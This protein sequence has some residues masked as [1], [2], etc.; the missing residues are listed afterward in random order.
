MDNWNN[1]EQSGSDSKRAYERW[2]EQ[3]VNAEN[4][5]A[6]DSVGYENSANNQS[7]YTTYNANGYEQDSSN[8]GYSS[9]DRTQPMPMQSNASY[10]LEEP[11]SLGEWIISLA[12]AYLIPCAGI[13]MMFV[14]AFSSDEKKSKSNF[15]K[16][17][18]IMMGIGMLLSL[19]FWGIMIALAIRY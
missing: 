11:V 4:V 3:D 10:G 5:N 19:I 1:S 6:S 17:N 13:V 16:A 8:T 18:L 14:W 15:F 12:I 2:M 7:G 9:W